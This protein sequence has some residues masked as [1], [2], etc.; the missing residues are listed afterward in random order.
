LVQ[1]ERILSSPSLPMR[2]KLT[3]ALAILAVLSAL[4]SLA[5]LISHRRVLVHQT[6]VNP[7]DQYQIADWGNVGAL[8]TPYL[9]C[10]YFT[11]R[12]IQTKVLRYLPDNN[13]L[14]KDQ[15]PF[16]ISP[17]WWSRPQS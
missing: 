15:C 12:G 17:A 8:G 9:V 6:M 10:R 1:F 5:L 16:F 2:T 3:S 7:G 13:P 4:I 11:G 14:G